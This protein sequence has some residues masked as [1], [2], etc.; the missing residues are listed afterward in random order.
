MDLI[1]FEDVV[2]GEAALFG[3][4]EITKDEIF[5]FAA[6]FDPQPFHLDEEAAKKTLLGGLSAS[7]W[8]TAAISMRL[9]YDSFL[10]HAASMGAPGVDELKWLK[11]VRPGD[12]LSLRVNVL[13][14]KES[15]SRPDL[16]LV[17]TQSDVF[18]QNGELVMTYRA[19]LMLR[20][21]Q[22]AAQ[23]RS[24]D[25]PQEATSQ[26]YDDV[27]S[28]R[29]KVMNAIDSK[30]LE[31]DEQMGS[32]TLRELDSAGKAAQRRTF[33]HPAV[34]EQEASQAAVAAPHHYPFFEDL[35][36]GWRFDLEPFTFD[37]AAI[38][39]FGKKYDPQPFHV[40]EAAARKSHFGGLVASGW[41]TVSVYMRQLIESRKK[42]LA[43]SLARGE[44]LPELGPSP[45]FNNLRWRAPVYAGDTLHFT[46]EFA[47]KR[48][49]SRPG[50]GLGFFQNKAYNQNDRLVFEFQALAFWQMRQR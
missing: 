4:Y 7:G 39:A 41:H 27:G 8:H 42:L 43:E 5:E 19:P 12:R 48:T 24:R 49:V 21:R 15:Q 47:D 40:D 44:K 18:N 13:E 31:R 9:L 22:A 20:R 1:Y 36:V 30:S 33:P 10:V 29:S 16:G 25:A 2:P 35:A 28:N 3:D 45:G 14:K 6:Q 32:G 11:P 17:Q 37:T 46:S 34:A 38:L 23:P 26:N 50:W